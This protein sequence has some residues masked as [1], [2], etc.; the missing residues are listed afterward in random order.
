MADTKYTRNPYKDDT[1]TIS[2]LNAYN[3]NKANKPGEFTY[4]DYT[5]SESVTNAQNMLNNLQKPSAYQSRWQQSLDEAMNKILNREKF[6]Y[7]VNGDALY[8]Q[9][10]D[11]YINQGRMAMMDTMGQASAM[12]GGYGSSYA[13]TAGNQAYQGYLQQL[14]DRVPELYKLALDKY[15]QE[16]QE[17]YNQ[18]GL[19]A[20]REDTDYGRYRDT[21]SDYYADRDYY[22]NAY[23]NE[24]NWDYGLYTDAYNR[25][26]NQYRDS[27]SDW[28]YNDTTLRNEYW[29]N[30]NFGYGKYVDDEDFRYS[31]Y[32]NSILDNQTAHE[33]ALEDA[34][35]AASL[36]DY[37]KL[38]ALG[39]DTSNAEAAYKASTSGGS[40]SKG[41]TTT[42]AKASD[43]ERSMMEDFVS[44]G[45]LD[46]LE[47]YLKGLFPNDTA[48]QD[49]WYEWAGALDVDVEDPPVISP[50][51]PPYKDFKDTAKEVI[52]GNNSGVIGR[53]PNYPG[54]PT[55]P[56]ATGTT[57]TTTSTKGGTNNAKN[58]K[59]MLN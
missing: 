29:N 20:D 59:Y 40:G 32:R 4:N 45:D 58:K 36:G 14:N 3:A 33:N 53:T 39:Y 35:V 52:Y 13:S 44:N 56:I 41:G 23:N 24:R 25:A 22:T 10:K 51:A 55:L 46:G 8:Q 9:Y 19:F 49:Y 18:Y 50:V 34:K 12:T 57:K 48:A 47:K 43:S 2:A 54:A 37:S 7:D 16:G 28:Q 42:I 26:Y 15:N 38:K 11:Q 6:T 1:E 27:V 5:P 21:M 17:L 30:K 31:E